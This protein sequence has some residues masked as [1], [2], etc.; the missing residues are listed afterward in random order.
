MSGYRRRLSRRRGRGHPL[1]NG[2]LVLLLALLV[3]VAGA[4]AVAANWVVGVLH[5][6]P[7]IARIRPKPQGAI[8]TVYAGDGL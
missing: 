6:T 2:L 4:G 1:R 3:A 5:H 8:S 7:D